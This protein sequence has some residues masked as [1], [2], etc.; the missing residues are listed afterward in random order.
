MHKHTYIHTH[1]ASTSHLRMSYTF[2][3]NGAGASFSES[4]PQRDKSFTTSYSDAFM[5]MPSTAYPFFTPSPTDMHVP[6]DV[7]PNKL[8]CWPLVLRCVCVCVC[9]R[10][11]VY[12]SCDV[13]SNKLVRWPLVST[14]VCVYTFPSLKELICCHVCVVCLCVC[15]SGRKQACGPCLKARTFMN[16]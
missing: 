2:G 12:V 16:L 9:V 1:T 3:S 13:F 4:I 11:R 10:I 7:F 5:S 6:C 15:V 8:V 14:C